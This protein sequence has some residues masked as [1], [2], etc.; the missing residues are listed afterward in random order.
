[1]CPGKSFL[2]KE[3]TPTPPLRAQR[4]G[5]NPPGSVK[6]G[7][8]DARCPRLFV[9]KS[10]LGGNRAA[11]CNCSSWTAQPTSRGTRVAYFAPGA[12]G[13]P[14]PGVSVKQL[15]GAYGVSNAGRSV[16]LGAGRG[17]RRG[18]REAVCA[19]RAH[20]AWARGAGRC[21]PTLRG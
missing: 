10:W 2:S 7:R 9:F 17:E 15:H 1:M 6:G 21:E 16:G 19:P 13:S 8:A 20:T 5:I 18:V 11:S 12:R 3:Q 4:A 14:V